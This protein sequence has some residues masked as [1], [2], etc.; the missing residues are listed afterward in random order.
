MEGVELVGSGSSVSVVDF[1]PTANLA[2][3]D[4]SGLVCILL[5]LNYLQR[6]IQIY[7]IIMH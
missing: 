6:K 4:E 3:G 1:S 7:N 5:D 2:I